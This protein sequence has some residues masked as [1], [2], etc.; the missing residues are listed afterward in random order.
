MAAPAPFSEEH[1]RRYDASR[2]TWE[3]MYEALYLFM[4]GALRGLPD[5][6]H[7]LIV[8]AGTGEE[9]LALAERRPRWRFTAVDPARP[10]L[11]R[12]R[13][14]AAAAG[15]ADRCAFHDGTVETLP[16]GAP[17][18]A[19]TA[20]L[21]SHFVVDRAA[22]VGFFRAIADRLRPGAALISADLAADLQ[23][24][25]FEPLFDLWWSTLHADG[26]PFGDKAAYRGNFGVAVAVVPP[27]EILAILDDAGFEAPACFFQGLM[28]HAFFGHRR[29]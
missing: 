9:L 1:A 21:V 23:A 22:R 26:S 18:D 24:P 11:D 3:P 4:E 12:A 10:M 7:L 17:F 2:R 20:L 29:A 14:K 28:I 6:A 13:E 15:I 8:G 27:G 19:A 16:P 5:D 25:G